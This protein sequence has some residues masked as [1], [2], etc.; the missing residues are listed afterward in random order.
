MHYHRVLIILI[1]ILFL[2]TPLQ[3]TSQSHLFSYETY[4]TSS[5]D[6]LLYRQLISDYSSGAKYP[7]VIFLHGAGERGL[8][9][10]A[11]LKWGVTHFADEE[12]MKSEMPIVIAPQCPPEL[13]WGGLTYEDVPQRGPL[14]RPMEILIELIDKKISA[15]NIDTN[16][17]YITGLSMG[18]FGTF[19]IISRRPEL[20][21]AAVPVCG[22]GDIMLAE[23]F[24]HIPI[25]IFHGALDDVVSPNLSMNMH[26]ALIKAGAQPGLTIYPN[27]GHFSWLGVYSDKMMM[28]WL[29]NQN[30]SKR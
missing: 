7:L 19:D 18:A 15:G 28:T 24:S 3:A 30:L 6:S 9:N 22:G 25:W 21:A 27:V 12:L 26:K 17:I 11:Q 23:S 8:D 14:T 10:E 2:N 29:F 13:N 1:G 4:I 20:F 5:G 16:R